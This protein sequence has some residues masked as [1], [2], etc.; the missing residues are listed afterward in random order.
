MFCPKG[1]ITVAE[2]A[3]LQHGVPLYMRQTTTPRWLLLILNQ[4]VLLK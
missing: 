1:L 3:H 4:K 2:S